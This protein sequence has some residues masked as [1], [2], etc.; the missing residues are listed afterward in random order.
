M[1]DDDR[2]ALYAGARA[3]LFP[4]LHEGFGFPALEAL[5]AGLP[6]LASDRASLPEVV[7]DAGILLDPN[8]EAA[9]VAALTQIDRDEGLRQ[10]AQRAGPGARAA[11]PLGGNG[12]ADPRRFW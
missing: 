6:V 3:L 7:G 11:V 4:A 12:A 1:D 10:T 9:W 8:D 2:G 5:H